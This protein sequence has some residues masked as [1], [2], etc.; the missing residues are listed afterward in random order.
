MPE[1]HERL[2]RIALEEAARG[3]AEGNVAVG[4]IIVQDETVVA[5]GR[6]LVTTDSDPTAHAE[7]VALRNAG[8]A[9]QRTDFSGCTL[10]TTFEPCPMCCGA[11]LVSGITTLVMGARSAPPERRWGDYSVEALIAHTQRS[12]QIAVVTGILTQECA[13]VRLVEG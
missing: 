10:Y 7:T 3:G 11:I 4:S 13:D 8:A 12:D 5:R 2:M 9:L 1:E 6:N